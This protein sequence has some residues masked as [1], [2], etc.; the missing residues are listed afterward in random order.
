MKF[1]ITSESNLSQDKSDIVY[2]LSESI[3]LNLKQTNYGEDIETFLI[4]LICVKS[5]FMEFLPV[6]K[7]KYTLKKIDDSFGIRTEIFKSYG[8]DIAMDYEKAMEASEFEFKELLANEIVKSFKH[9][10]SMPKKVKDFDKER[11]KAD[12]VGL[13]ESEGLL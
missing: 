11:F 4:G 12:V 7:P 13:L 8:Y 5:E 6:R 1:G 10:D 3:N 9:L 2:N